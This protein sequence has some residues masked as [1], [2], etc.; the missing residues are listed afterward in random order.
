[1]GENGG[2]VDRLKELLKAI[3]ALEE[4]NK[5]HTFYVEFC[6]QQQ[7][8]VLGDMWRRLLHTLTAL[9]KLEDAGEGLSEGDVDPH[10]SH[11]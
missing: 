5:N 8:N 2:E 7:R 3:R 10:W 9:Q 11:T 4:L 6:S 1:M